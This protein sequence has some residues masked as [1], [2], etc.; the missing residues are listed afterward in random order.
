MLG[1]F[2]F[3]PFY[4]WLCGAAWGGMVEYWHFTGDKSY[5]DVTYNA[6]VA[7]ISPTHNYLPVAEMYD[8]VGSH[9]I[10]VTLRSQLKH[11]SIIAGKRRRRLLGLRRHVRHR[12]RLP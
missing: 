7:Q 12:T 11:D 8:E 4:W 1:K 9:P 2:P 10:E 5:Y 3:P 6:L